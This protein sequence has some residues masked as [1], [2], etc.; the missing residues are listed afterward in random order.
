MMPVA[1]PGMDLRNL[2]PHM[3]QLRGFGLNEN[4]KE[5]IPQKPIKRVVHA[6]VRLHDFLVQNGIYDSEEYWKDTMFIATSKPPCRLCYHYFE[7]IDSEFEIQSPHM[8]TYMKWRLP[9]IYKE[10]DDGDPSEALCRQQ[11]LLESIV[12]RMQNDVLHIINE[13]KPE[14][15]TNDSRTG[16]RFGS[17]TMER[18]NEER[19][20][21]RTSGG[22]SNGPIQPFRPLGSLVA[23][24]GP[25]SGMG[26]LHND[27][28]EMDRGDVST[29]KGL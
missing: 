23:R 19:S 22:Q 27:E 6:E 10:E 17:S 29:G 25:A 4:I 8:N 2:Q 9:D 3:D 11:V 1:F 13:K 12:D 5:K 21:S 16:T 26:Y 15:S 18:H 7:I 20:Y 24:I 28:K 14:G